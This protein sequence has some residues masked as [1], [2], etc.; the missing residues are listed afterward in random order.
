MTLAPVAGMSMSD[1]YL[2]LQRQQE[3]E[4]RRRKE[5]KSK[6]KKGKKKKGDSSSE[7]EDGLS[8]AISVNTEYDVPEV[9]MTP[10][11]GVVESQTFSRE[12]HGLNPP[13]AV[14]KH[15]HFCS[16][17]IARLFHCWSL[18]PGVCAKLNIPHRVNVRRGLT[19]SNTTKSSA[20]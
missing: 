11:G 3:A 1:K 12:C 4:R 17:H 10:G 20:S 7:S 8:A 5:K 19:N 15:G 13:A 9:S 14:L 6:K 16:P 18:L 2:Q